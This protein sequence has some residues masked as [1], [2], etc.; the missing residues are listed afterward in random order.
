[1]MASRASSA[2][3]LQMASVLAGIVL[4]AS[5][6]GLT[7]SLSPTAGLETS[8]RNTFD[9]AAELYR[10]GNFAESEDLL[11]RLSWTSA[12]PGA[13]HNLGNAEFKLGN[14]GPAILAWEKAHSLDPWNRNTSANLRFVRNHAALLP[15]SLSWSEKYSSWLP[16]DCW[17]WTASLCFWIGLACLALPSLLARRRTAWTQAGAVVTLSAFILTLPALAGLSSR[18]S[19]G[20]VTRTEAPLR[21]TPTQEGEVLGK[22]PAGDVARVELTR[23]PYLYVRGDGDRAG[24]V[25]GDEFTRIWSQ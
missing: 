15:P 17:L 22:L 9:K 10:A 6:F 12:A 3:P 21:L 23:G 13:L 16:A 8:D 18:A 24:W 14:V 19:L 1:M 4:S 11:N 7:P 2:I 20:V 25:H 5:S